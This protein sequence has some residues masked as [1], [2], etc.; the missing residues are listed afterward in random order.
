[1][2]YDLYAAQIDTVVTRR[3]ANGSFIAEQRDAR[4]ALTRTL[5]GGD[6]CTRIVTFGKNNV[7]WSGTCALANSFENVHIC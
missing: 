1:M 7:L 3:V 6:D 4:D 5:R 2:V